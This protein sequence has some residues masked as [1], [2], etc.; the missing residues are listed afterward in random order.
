MPFLSCGFLCW[1][2]CVFFIWCT[3]INKHTSRKDMFIVN[4]V[5]VSGSCVG[6]GFFHRDIYVDIGNLSWWCIGWWNLP[7]PVLLFTNSV[8]GIH[9][10]FPQSERPMRNPSYPHNV[11]NR[12][13]WQINTTSSFFSG[14]QRGPRMDEPWWSE[15][16]CVV[17]LL[18]GCVL[19]PYFV[20]D[21]EQ[22]ATIIEDSQFVSTLIGRIDKDW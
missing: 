22:A 2:E 4:P 16:V 17:S 14:C 21:R 9:V 8:K 18:F 11:F 15:E 5:F 1:R 13:K 3:D 10:A 12:S 19:R 6:V 7:S 20:D